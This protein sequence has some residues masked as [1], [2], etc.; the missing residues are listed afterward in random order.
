M[1]R[2]Y[3]ICHM[4]QSIDGKVTG[5]FLYTPQCRAATDVYYEINRDYSHNGF[6]CGRVTMES[7]FTQGYRPDL[8]QYP[9][10]ES[11]DDF[12]DVELSEFYAVSFDPK[13]KVGWT[14]PFIDDED[15]G[16]DMAQVIEVVSSKVDRKYLGYLRTLGIPY[17]F[18]GEDEIDVPL[19]LLKLKSLG[20]DTLLLEGGSVI[21][22]YFQRAE[23]IDE[24]SLVVAPVVSQ[25][26]GKPL[27]DNENFA[28]F[29][30]REIKEYDD[31]VLWLNYTKA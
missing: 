1:D 29:S 26:D 20:M 10:I 31:S 28:N 22:G 24:L 15:P 3:I 30:L 11:N 23:C 8:T 6:I 4:V 5:D 19:A 18:A 25:S 7:S 13:G 2:P 27:F 12:T 16:Y 21:N 14:A 9:A 17:I